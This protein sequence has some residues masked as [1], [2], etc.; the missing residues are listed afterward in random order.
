M[1]VIMDTNE[2][3]DDDIAQF[4]TTLEADLKNMDKTYFASA[5]LRQRIVDKLE[6]TVLNMNIITEVSDRDSAAA[7]DSQMNVVNT[8][9]NLLNDAD[10][11]IKTKIEIKT[12]QREL[13]ENGKQAEA[14]IATLNELSKRRAEAKAAGTTFTTN[15]DAAD[16][17]LIERIQTDNI[18]VN[19][20]ELRED[21]TDL[22]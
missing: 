11:A 5:D 19:D 3:I 2:Q 6:S 18:E 15:M 14:F 4:Q 17:A 10:K 1:G 16:A 22:T 8:L 7:L 13:I 21:P 20:A 12:K 9:A